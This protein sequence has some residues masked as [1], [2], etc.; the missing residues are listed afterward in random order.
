MSKPATTDAPAAHAPAKPKGSDSWLR[1]NLEAVAVAIIMALLI[2][3]FCVEAFRIPTSSM[4][5]TLYGQAADRSGDRILVNKVGYFLGEPDRW[6]VVVFK[7]PL[8]RS[9]NYIKR[10]IG[11]GG[12]TIDIRGGDIWVD[13]KIARKP[14]AVQAAL[15]RTVFTLDRAVGRGTEELADERGRSALP[16]NG[17]DDE[18]EDPERGL[19]RAMEFRDPD[20][21]ARVVDGRLRLDAHGRSAPAWVVMPERGPDGLYVAHT[22]GR[23]LDVADVRLRCTLTATPGQAGAVWLRLG[24][25]DARFRVRLPVGGGTASVWHTAPGE[26][27]D[28]LGTKLALEPAVDLPAGRPVRLEA[29]HVDGTLVVLVD[30][31]EGIRH[32]YEPERPP[33]DDATWD[34]LPA[35]GAEDVALEVAELDLARDLHYRRGDYPRRLPFHVPEGH[36]L[37]LGD[38]SG[39]SKDSRMWFSVEF[40]V[41]DGLV[42]G[43][44][45]RGDGDTGATGDD[46]RRQYAL[47]PDDG[48]LELVDDAG[49]LWQLRREQV[50]NFDSPR[51]ADAPFVP[52]ENVVGRAFFVFFPLKRI[53]FIR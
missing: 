38:N 11:K 48:T 12:E 52:R 44:V 45:I 4:E 49:R 14:A 46:G 29:A 42:D 30:R 6:H 20:K 40:D 31:R 18:P 47:D 3:H 53:S 1:D 26:P 16:G 41:V 15:W 7:Y 39:S 35:L 19:L 32:G 27:R 2:R 5:P 28:S 10:L 25:G 17:G 43:N 22:E 36:Y 23:L 51:V 24:P 21:V 34:G 8:N 37:M 9:R 13:G 33:T 50:V